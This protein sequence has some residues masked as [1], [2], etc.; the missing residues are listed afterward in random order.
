MSHPGTGGGGDAPRSRRRARL[1][2]SPRTRER[3]RL[4]VAVQREVQPL[5]QAQVRR[6]RSVDAASYASL[7]AFAAVSSAAA[8][9]SRPRGVTRGNARDRRG[10]PRTRRRGLQ[11]T[12][13]G[14]RAPRPE[15]F[16]SRAP[17][18]GCAANTPCTVSFWNVASASLNAG[19]LVLAYAESDARRVD[20]SVLSLADMDTMLRRS[21]RSSEARGVDEHERLDH[22]EEVVTAVQ[23]GKTGERR[24]LG[25]EKI[26]QP[27]RASAAPSRSRRVKVH[28]EKVPV[29]LRDNL[30]ERERRSKLRRDGQRR[31][32]LVETFAGVRGRVHET[33]PGVPAATGASSPAG[34]AIHASG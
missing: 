5:V 10:D 22:H 30:R 7:A 28:V 13:R 4:L 16:I 6:G 29:F 21:V 27:N 17:P 26:R 3:L 20:V 15:F 8:T 14:A 24:A 12:P 31:L 1:L 11:R 25:G 33:R 23:I 32:E 19:S 9:S 2:T 18:R 34:A